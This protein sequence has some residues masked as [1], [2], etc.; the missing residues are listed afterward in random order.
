MKDHGTVIQNMSYVTKS[1]HASYPEF[2][3]PVI[4]LTV[5]HLS[6]NPLGANPLLPEGIPFGKL[7]K[8]SDS[9]VQNLLMKMTGTASD[10]TD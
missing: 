5:P 2:V 4:A 9:Q 6:A 1:L 3:L 7:R 8:I 10:K